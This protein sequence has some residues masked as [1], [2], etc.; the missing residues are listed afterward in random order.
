MKALTGADVDYTGYIVGFAACD[1]VIECA[2]PANGEQEVDR[3]AIFDSR[4][5]A[6]CCFKAG[7]GAGCD[8]FFF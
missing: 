4:K 8:P 5:G 2:G 1:F 6:S 7:P 3:T